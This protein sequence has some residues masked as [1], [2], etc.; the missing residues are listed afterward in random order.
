MMR[1]TGFVLTCMICTSAAAQENS[2]YS[3]Y[4][5]GDITPNQNIVNRGMGGIAAGYYDFQ[6]I[7]FV[8]PATYGNLS[9]LTPN[10]IRISPGAQRNTIF[11]FGIEGDS[12]TLKS[13][14][15]A[16]KYTSTNLIISYMELGLP[17]K[18]KKANKKGIFMGVDIGLRPVSRI[19]YKIASFERRNDLNDSLVTI[20]EGSGG[21]SEATLGAGFRIR[22]FNFGFN[23]GYRFG[24]KSYSTKLSFI[25]D[26]VAYYQSNSASDASFGGVF[27][28]VGTQ[29]E[30]QLKNK[31]RKSAGVLRLGAYA[32][33]SQ[34]MH[35]TQDISRQTFNLDASGAIYKIDSVY[36]LDQEGTV[37]T[38]L[39][40]GAGF[41]Y[42]DSSGAWTFGADY[43]RTNWDQ[44]R[45][46]D[47]TDKVQNSWKIR[48]GAEYFPASKGA[49]LSKYF[50]FV[51]YRAGVYF[52]PDYINT[53][54]NMPE[55]GFTFGASFPLKLRKSS[56][57]ET[58]LSYLNTAIEIGSRGNKQ[59]TLRE[60]TFRVC[61][62][63]SLGDLWFNRSKYY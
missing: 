15:P 7:N 61:L 27:L 18:L 30:I 4:G 12:R 22:N 39:T 24:T 46:F 38:P 40:W 26:T 41:T 11:A 20:Y 14:D 28:N 49:S 31:M 17:I 56:Y 43:E 19:N 50:R 45:F 63:F 8:N 13:T 34:E 9:Y 36:Q 59:T 25:N 44:Y 48:A 6:S 29:Y 52:G 21:V 58:Q 1:L 47:S 10:T 62:G 23:S 32:N 2:P 37:V 57:Y 54:V 3:R 5:L 51:K 53:G 35:G 42:Q 60:S 33:L 55:Y 16:G